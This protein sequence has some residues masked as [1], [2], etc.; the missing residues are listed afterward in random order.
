MAN[1]LYVN[2]QAL[3]DLILHPAYQFWAPIIQNIPMRNV[4]IEDRAF[5]S[6]PLKVE[7]EYVYLTTDMKFV[8]CREG[9][10]SFLYAEQDLSFRFSADDE[11]ILRTL[12]GKQFSGIIGRVGQVVST[13]QI[14]LVDENRIYHTLFDN[15]FISLPT[16]PIPHK[17][18]PVP[19]PRPPPNGL[20]KPGGKPGKLGKLGKLEKPGK[21]GKPGKLGKAAPPPKKEPKAK[22]QAKPKAGDLIF[23]RFTIEV[24]EEIIDFRLTSKKSYGYLEEKYD[25]PER[26]LKV[27]FAMQRLRKNRPNAPLKELENELGDATPSNRGRKPKAK[28]PA[29]AKGKAKGKGKANDLS[30]YSNDQKKQIIHMKTVSKKSYRYVAQKF[31]VPI[32]DVHRICSQDLKR[33]RKS[34][35]R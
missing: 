24:C 27:L 25:F 11:G 33:P 26:D 7:N 12:D 5:H 30:K 28:E 15:G 31:K 17:L 10:L 23:G 8:Y 34:V 3:A 13:S 20:T 18:P 2:D 6:R 9:M 22:K 29:A 19:P 35:K 21:P 16:P 4:P 1:L 32:D 14:K